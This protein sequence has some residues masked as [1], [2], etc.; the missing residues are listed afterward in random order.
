MLQASTGAFRGSSSA[1][2]AAAA[3]GMPPG[4]GLLAGSAHSRRSDH[5]P[6]GAWAL[7]ASAL[8]LRVHARTCP[9]TL[10]SSQPLTAYPLSSLRPIRTMYMRLHVYAVIC[11]ENGLVLDAAVP[12][13]S[14]PYPISVGT[15][16]PQP[17]RG[18]EGV[19]HPRGA[20]PCTPLLI[21]LR[22]SLLG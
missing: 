20:C 13:L 15:G 17:V 8:V 21:H 22:S 16:V 4:G 12:T 5:G 10:C 11:L 19:Q 18:S 9:G 14:D 3:G 2:P 6:H 7:P 1:G